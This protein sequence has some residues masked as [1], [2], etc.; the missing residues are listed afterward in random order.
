MTQFGEALAVGQMDFRFT[1]EYFGIKSS[2]PAAAKQAQIS[3]SFTV[4][5]NWNELVG[6]K[7]FSTL[8]AIMHTLPNWL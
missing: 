1:P 2:D 3:S 6:S 8:H 7:T 5:D 4:S